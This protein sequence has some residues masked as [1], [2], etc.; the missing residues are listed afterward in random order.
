MIK[1][2]SEVKVDE[3][4]FELALR[5]A[6]LDKMAEVYRKSLLVIDIPLMYLFYLLLAGSSFIYKA[7]GISIQNLAPV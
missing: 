4:K 5:S 1:S 2:S 6:E 7:L 3:V